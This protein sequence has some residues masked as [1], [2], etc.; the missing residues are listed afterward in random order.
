MKFLHLFEAKFTRSLLTR[1]W[2][3]LFADLPPRVQAQAEQTFQK[4]RAHPDSVPCTP[5]TKIGHRDIYK[6]DLPGWYRTVG[7]QVD[8]NTIEWQWIGSH[9]DY[10]RVWK[11]M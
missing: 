2:R 4:W 8:P 5:F 9:E 11:R 6:I 7:Q 1:K 3:K 10:N